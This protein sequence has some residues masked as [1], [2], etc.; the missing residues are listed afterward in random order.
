MDLLNLVP[1]GLTCAFSLGA[2][3]VALLLDR[4]VAA[5]AQDDV[6]DDAYPDVWFLH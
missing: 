4:R 6:A 1:L 3:V 5:T 2:W